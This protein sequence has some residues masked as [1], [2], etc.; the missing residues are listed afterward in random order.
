MIKRG[1]MH[2]DRDARSQKAIEALLDR[3]RKATGEDLKE[4][5][6]SLKRT[7]PA[8]YGWLPLK[9]VFSHLVFA[10]FCFGAYFS[11]GQQLWVGVIFFCFSSVMMFYRRLD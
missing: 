6:A 9:G 11:Y 1:T 5:C 4:I 7:R 3:A 8:R 10:A 2:K